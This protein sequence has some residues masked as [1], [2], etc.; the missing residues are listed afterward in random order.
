MKIRGT[1]ECQSCGTQWSYY[2]TGSVA[3]PDC[4]GMRSVGVDETRR[5]HTD[6]P[7]DLELEPVRRRLATESI[8]DVVDE[9]KETLRSYTRKRGFIAGGE[10]RELDDTYLAARELLHASDLVARS[11]EPSEAEEL[12]VLAVLRQAESGEWPPEADLPDSLA[13][14]R[15]L[16]VAESVEAYRRD[17]RTWLDEHPDPEAAHTLGTLRDQLKRAEALQGAIGLETAEGLV[18]VARE[19]GQYLRE[20]DVDALASARDRL[21]RLG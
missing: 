10:L 3:C 19:I 9:L 14:A 16:A 6:S 4:G 1:R 21:Q 17:L 7:A 11:R 8:E 12:Y 18:A 20:G 5:Q 2:E 15:G 13:A